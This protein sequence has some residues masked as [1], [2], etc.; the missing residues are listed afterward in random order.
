MNKEPVKQAFKTPDTNY[1]TK[2]YD[3]VALA[4]MKQ[5]A[6]KTLVDYP[7]E[8]QRLNIALKDD[9]DVVLVALKIKPSLFR[10]ASPRLRTDAD[11]IV[12]SCSD[13]EGVFHLMRFYGFLYQK[14]RSYKIDLST[15]IEN[16]EKWFRQKDDVFFRNILT[17]LDKRTVDDKNIYL[18]PVLPWIPYTALKSYVQQGTLRD[19]LEDERLRR[20]IAKI[21]KSNVPQEKPSHRSRRTLKP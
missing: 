19:T 17:E 8:L 1:A 2:V 16:L 20:D 21:E 7:D 15:A 4:R 10:Y 13:S 6:L 5:R 14:K 12:T 11:I 3:P 18:H 9:K